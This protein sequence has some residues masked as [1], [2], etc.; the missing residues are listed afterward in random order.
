MNLLKVL[1][2]IT[3]AAGIAQAS[4]FTA[5]A[6]KSPV[7]FAASYSDAH[8]KSHPAQTVKAMGLKFE[9]NEADYGDMIL[10]NIKAQ[11]KTKKGVKP[12][13][14]GMACKFNEANTE[15]NCWIDCDG[16]SATIQWD[17][18]NDGNDNIK[19][20]NKG[21]VMYGGCGDDVA[22]GDMIWLAPKK[23]GDDIFKFKKLD[24]KACAK[25]KTK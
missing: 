6:D 19:L 7:C 16:G 14:S 25:I 24:A 1:L 9:K 8:M 12:Y 4:P 21:F 2:T 13:H 5:L 15:M 10:M 18:K 17:L 20:I 3:F 22:D 23:G 11:I